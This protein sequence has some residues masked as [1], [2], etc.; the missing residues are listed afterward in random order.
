MGVSLVSGEKALAPVS[1]YP[2]TRPAFE[3]PNGAS[4]LLAGAPASRRTTLEIP[5]IST[6]TCWTMAARERPSWY[7]S[8]VPTT[9]LPEGQGLLV[10][11]EAL[12]EA[13]S[14]LG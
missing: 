12:R 9:S 14:E 2:T 4:A 1:A 11:P 7:T 8:P 5:G 6:P 13:E 10:K 3:N